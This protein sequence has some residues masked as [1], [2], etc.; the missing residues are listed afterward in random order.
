MLYGQVA[1]GKSLRELELSFNSH[2]GH[3]YHL[4][5]RSIK[6]STLSDANNKRDSAFYEDLCRQLLGKMWG[7][8][9]SEMSD[10]L[11]L[12]DSTPIP[13]RGLG[14]QWPPHAGIKGSHDDRR[15]SARPCLW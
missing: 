2:E 10:M 12:L 14:C 6:R 9:K 3:H 4:G 15:E 5:T 13:L 8:L 7:K 1:G 11:Y